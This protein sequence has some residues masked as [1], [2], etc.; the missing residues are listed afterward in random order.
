MIRDG[1]D[2]RKERVRQREEFV[3]LLDGDGKHFEAPPRRV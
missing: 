1:W 2:Q 3:V